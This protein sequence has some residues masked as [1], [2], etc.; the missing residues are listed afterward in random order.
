MG[1]RK[2]FALSEALA[3]HCHEVLTQDLAGYSFGETLTAAQ[4]AGSVE[5]VDRW[6]A[7]LARL[8]Q[9]QVGATVV[10]E[11]DYPI[12]LRMVFDRPPVL[13]FRGSLV[14][15]DSR[16]VSIVGTRNPSDAGRALAGRVA[17]E[18]AKRHV[19]IISGM[20]RGIDTAAHAG[21]MNAGGRTIAVLGQGICTQLP[22][23]RASFASAI[24]RSGAVISQFWP[25]QPATTWTF[26]I[27]N[28]V[29][30]GLSLATVVIEAGP[31]SGAK[32][33]ALDA[34]NHGRR[35]FLVK[36]LVL[37][38]EWAQEMQDC[39]GVSVLGD[40]LDELVAAIDADLSLGQDVLV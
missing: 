35:V 39:P 6:V 37:Q 36:P 10:C 33:Q 13:F 32:L 20:A 7:E 15:D 28:R 19:T 9:R 22:R 8:A 31:T 29:T 23:D 14:H 38:Q 16:S 21:A 4:K 34:L 2:M 5:A 17:G 3:D 24:A 12:N 11:D 30:S 25:E 18:L 1:D 27:R 40:D 26:P